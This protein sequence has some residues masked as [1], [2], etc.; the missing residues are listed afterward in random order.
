MFIRFSGILTVEDLYEVDPERARFLRELRELVVRKQ[1]VVQDNTLSPEAKARQIQNLSLVSSDGSRL[2]D[3][4][5]TF[6][7]LPSSK[8]YGF[9]SHDLVNNGSD[10][11]VGHLSGFIQNGTYLFDVSALLASLTTDCIGGCQGEG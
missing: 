9:N 11:E 8:V 4:M 1:R 7:Y 3:L 2:E 6:T 5:I 10:I